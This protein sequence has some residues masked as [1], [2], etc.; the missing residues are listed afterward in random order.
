MAHRDRTGNGKTRSN[1]MILYLVR[2]PELFTFR[3]RYVF[4]KQ[5]I[6]CSH[7]QNMNKISSQSSY[8][9]FFARILTYLLCLG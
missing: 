5:R 9:T 3:A 2:K 4:G 6:I 7:T 8:V 1:F